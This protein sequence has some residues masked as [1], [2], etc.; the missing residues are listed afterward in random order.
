MDIQ[1]FVVSITAVC[2]PPPTP[3]KGIIPSSL[4]R[5]DHVGV[6]SQTR[7]QLRGHLRIRQV[8]LLWFADDVVTCSWSDAAFGWAAQ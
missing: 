8:T 5:P 4:K 6:I 3:P 1:A 7:G 2:P